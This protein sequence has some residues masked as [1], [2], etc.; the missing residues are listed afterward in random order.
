M[1]CRKDDPRIPAIDPPAL[2]LPPALLCLTAEMALR[3]TE[4]SLRSLSLTQ[5][6]Q[7]HKRAYS[8][9]WLFQRKSAGD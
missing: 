4:A 8:E 2:P 6:E 3:L 9:H 1:L 7:P 5:L